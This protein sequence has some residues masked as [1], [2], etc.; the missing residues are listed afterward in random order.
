[1]IEQLLLPKL[2]LIG[3]LAIWLGT[4]CSILIVSLIEAPPPAK[5]RALFNAFVS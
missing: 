2:V 4:N 5:L 3:G 1:M